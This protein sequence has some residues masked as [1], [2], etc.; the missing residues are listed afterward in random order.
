MKLKSKYQFTVVSI[1]EPPKKLYKCKSCGSRPVIMEL[2]EDCWTDG[3]YSPTTCVF[4]GWY[5]ECPS[6]KASSDV[7]RDRKLAIRGWNKND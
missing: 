1:Q 4:R 3:P 5:V 7:I 6:C 2:Y